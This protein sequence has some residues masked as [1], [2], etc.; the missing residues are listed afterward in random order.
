M[1]AR[2]PGNLLV[3]YV[4]AGAEEVL[5]GAG[6]SDRSSWALRDARLQVADQ[7]RAMEGFGET[8]DPGRSARLVGASDPTV[9]QFA[10]MAVVHR[11]GDGGTS[12]V[13]DHED[14]A[15]AALRSLLEDL[16][17]LATGD[18]QAADRVAALFEPVVEQL[19]TGELQPTT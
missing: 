4:A 14:R 7:L 10:A 13:E 3:P 11:V 8:G 1:A 6:L 2:I 15:R 18:A 12:T 17:A 19:A 9:P 5:S 16:E